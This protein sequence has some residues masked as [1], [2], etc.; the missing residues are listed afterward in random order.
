MSWGG[1]L[2]VAAALASVVV[3]YQ[4]GRV[5]GRSEAEVKALRAD[6]RAQRATLV[7]VRRV[8]EAAVRAAD[9]ARQR[10]VTVRQQTEALTQE[11]PRRVPAKVDARF[12]LPLQLVRLHDAA[13]TGAQVSNTAGGAN[14]SAGSVAASDLARVIVSNYGECRADQARLAALQAWVA[15]AN[16]AGGD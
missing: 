6:L 16:S 3:A 11:I 13:A 10:I 7:A 9:P 4:H 5:Q 8:S 1:A 14:D 12:P 15:V 2:C